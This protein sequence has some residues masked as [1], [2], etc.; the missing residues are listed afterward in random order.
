MVAYL[1]DEDHYYDI[2]ELVCR[3]HKQQKEN[4]KKLFSQWPQMCV[5][6]LCSLTGC[7]ES[8]PM[9]SQTSQSN[10]SAK[11]CLFETIGS[12]RCRC[13]LTDHLLVA[14]ILIM[15]IFYKWIRIW[16]YGFYFS[17]G[18][19]KG[20]ITYMRN[21]GRYLESYLYTSKSISTVHSNK[22]I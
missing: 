22:V 8:D 18:R 19:N 9:T 20:I 1:G 6:C 13:H 3:S 15:S 14:L 2:A 4:L 5:K 12:R 16:K 21:N 10:S 11:A 17:N 7:F